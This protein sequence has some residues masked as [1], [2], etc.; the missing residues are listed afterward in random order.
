MRVRLELHIE[1]ISGGGGRENYS[2]LG[3]YFSKCVFTC[4]SVSPV[5]SLTPKFS[6]TSGVDLVCAFS[7]LVWTG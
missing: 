1:N 2:P 7:I 4:S 6:K 5:F 3:P